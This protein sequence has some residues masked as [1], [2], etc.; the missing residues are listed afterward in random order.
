MSDPELRWFR[1]EASV[2]AIQ[3]VQA[4]TAEEA[5]QLACEAADSWD[6]DLDAPI[7]AE[8]VVSV[9]EDD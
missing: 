4:R 8:H 6:V 2:P 7:E 9:Q 3:R 5:I 1:I